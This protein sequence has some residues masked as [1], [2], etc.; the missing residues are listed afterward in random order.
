[1]ADQV[2][3]NFYNKVS[4]CNHSLILEMNQAAV[5]GSST[6]GDILWVI[7]VAIFCD[8]AIIYETWG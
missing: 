3:V 1:M 5:N 8:R 6:K 7:L 2:T 4:Q